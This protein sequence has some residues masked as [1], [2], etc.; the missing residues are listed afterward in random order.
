MRDALPANVAF[1]SRLGTPEDRAKL[2]QA[3]VS[4]ERFDGA[5]I[6]VDGARRFAPS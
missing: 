4:N 2:V 5:V 1:P 3:I 6:W